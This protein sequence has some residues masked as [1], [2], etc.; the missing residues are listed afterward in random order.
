[1]DRLTMRE[2]RYGDKAHTYK[3]WNVLWI[4]R[5]L[6][7]IMHDKGVRELAKL[8]KEAGRIELRCRKCNRYFMNYTLTG[9]ADTVAL[10]NIELK[11]GRCKRMMVLQRCT[12]E[13]LRL[14]AVN[15]AYKI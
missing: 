6:T 8:G 5:L 13:V 11:C 2:I 12:E 4:F 9:E 7:N 14:H 3:E 15:G 1:M 10:Q